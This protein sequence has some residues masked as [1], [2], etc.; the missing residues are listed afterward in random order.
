MG[1]LFE[2]T[3]AQVDRIFGLDHFCCLELNMLAAQT[4]HQARSAAKQNRD[5]VDKE[6]INEYSSDQ[7][8]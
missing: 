8:T 2:D 5:E 6:F 7:A 3:K 4:F 1:F